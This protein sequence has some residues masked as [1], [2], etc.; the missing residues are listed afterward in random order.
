[1]ATLKVI[2]KRIASVKSTQKITKA[3]KM[4]AAAKL[5]RA[6]GALLQA[7]PYGSHLQE[8]LN[9]LAPYIPSESS[10]FLSE[11]PSKIASLLVFTSD[12]GLCGGFNSNLLRKVNFFVFQEAQK[13]EKIQINTVGKKA[14]D[15]FKARKIELHKEWQGLT[16]GFNF[17]KALEISHEIIA[18]FQRGEFGTFYLA[19]NGFKSAISQEIRIRKILPLEFHKQPHSGGEGEAATRAPAI[20]GDGIFPIIFEPSAPEL[21]DN[22]VPRY[23]ASQIYLAHLESSASE[24]GARMSAMENATSNAKEMIASLTLVYNRARQ[25]SI[26]KEL[27]DI[28]NGAESLK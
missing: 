23:V 15:F 10:P 9:T 24:L 1:M 11:A 13:H 16:I 8:I 4:V 3:M 7:R 27:M 6:Q 17:E 2:R 28:V 18:A 26:T 25:A 14:R 22:L 12:R 21:F 19:Y 5:R 20:T